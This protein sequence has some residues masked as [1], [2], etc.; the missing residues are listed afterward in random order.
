L[1]VYKGEATENLDA[2]LIEL[3]QMARFHHMSSQYTIELAV[4]RLRDTALTWW[5]ELGAAGQEA[6]TDVSQLAEGLRKRFQHHT[7]AEV[8]REQLH[9]LQQG[10]RS[11]DN[12]ILDF[13]R[14]VAK[15]PGMTD[16][17]AIFSFMRGLPKATAQLV[18]LQKVATLKEAT[19]AASRVSGLSA[20]PHT[21][22]SAAAMVHNVNSASPPADSINNVNSLNSIDQSTN[23]LHRGRGGRFNSSRGRFDNGRRGGANNSAEGARRP[24]RPVPG[25]PQEVA[26]QRWESK[27]CLRCGDHAHMIRDC[28]NAS[29]STPSSSSTLGN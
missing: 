7:A 11:T 28:T 5:E 25:V 29:S 14:L 18:R 6:I 4:A 19:A 8:A 24:A 9:T 20:P 16:E 1:A 17:E 10:N 13:Q 12:Y 3:K 21:L 2:W 26:Q 22:H 23:V 15:V 27:A